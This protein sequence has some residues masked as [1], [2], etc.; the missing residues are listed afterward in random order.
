MTAQRATFRKIDIT[1]AVQAV[2]AGGETIGRVEIENGKI[3]IV[4]SNEAAAADANPLDV[5]LKSNARN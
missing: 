5:W 4:L 3:V 1:R 2:R